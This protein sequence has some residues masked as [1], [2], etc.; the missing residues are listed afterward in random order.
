MCSLY[1]AM[2]MMMM[3]SMVIRVM[4]RMMTEILNCMC[5]YR[6][7]AVVY[8]H[9]NMEKPPGKTLAILC[10]SIAWQ[11]AERAHLKEVGATRKAPGCQTDQTLKTSLKGSDEVR[12][13]VSMQAVSLEDVPCV[14]ASHTG[15]ISTQYRSKTYQNHSIM[16]VAATLSLLQTRG[17]GG[18]GDWSLPASQD[19]DFQPEKP[20]KRRFC[21]KERRRPKVAT[22]GTVVGSSKSWM[23][24][25]GRLLIVAAD[26]ASTGCVISDRPAT[27]QSGAA[28]QEVA[29]AEGIGQ[30][31]SLSRIY[32]CSRTHSQVSQLIKGLRTTVYNPNM[33]VLGSRDQLCINP[34]VK[35]SNS[36]SE[37]CSK[38]IGGESTV[39]CKYFSGYNALAAQAGMLGVWDIE[40]LV[41]KG[42][43]VRTCPFFAAKDIAQTADVI[44]CPYTYLIDRWT[45][46]ASGINLTNSIVIFDEAHNLEDQCREAASFVVSDKLLLSAIAMIELCGKFPDCP[47]EAAPL[48]K[49]LEDIRAWIRDRSTSMRSE[50]SSEKSKEFVGEHVTRQLASM[51]LT[52][53]RVADL[54]NHAS[55]VQEWHKQVIA[56]MKLNTSE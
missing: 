10:S 12:S 17:G 6:W 19:D 30:Q 46:E 28:G 44:F 41:V 34:A 4:M 55:T 33:A 27:G 22:D 25:N 37:E 51:G 47:Y 26:P 11:Q 49:S 29:S 20:V 8:S 32:I 35:R 2:M 13:E 5:E 3:A 1:H 16:P 24:V 23:F 31:E 39:G 14:I 56:A 42:Q 15:L 45:R 54:S 52:S 48:S 53:S 9:F 18:G 36:K 7:F 21:G 38:L 43:Q 50:G 40:D